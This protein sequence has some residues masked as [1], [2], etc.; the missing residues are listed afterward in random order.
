[1]K[2]GFTLIELLVVIVI[3]GI[4]STIAY[5][6]IDKSIKNSRNN[7]YNVQLNQIYDGTESWVFDNIT[8]LENKQVYCVKLGTLEDEGYVE[9]GIINPKT[10]KKFNT[11]LYIKITQNIS[12]Y[13]YLLV[14]N[15]DGCE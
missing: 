13:D 9:K 11:D 14:E 2:N 6:T 5:V 3:V 7:L 12:G 10:D 8:K 4:L 1:M 15:N